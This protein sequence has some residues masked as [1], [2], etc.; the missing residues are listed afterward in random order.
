M[1]K[2]IIG[3]SAALVIAAI[4]G[5]VILKKDLVCEYSPINLSAI[6]DC[7]PVIDPDDAGSAEIQ[8]SD[9]QPEITGG[10]EITQQ[11]ADASAQDAEK[12]KAAE[13][14]KLAEEAAE[15]AAQDAAK[16]EEEAAKIAAAEKAVEQEAEPEKA[17]NVEITTNET[18]AEQTSKPV[19]AN[20]PTFDL[21]RVEPDG[22]TL[23]AG[24]GA[25]NATIILRDG[26]KN[27][28][29][30]ISGES[31]EWVIIVDE[32]IKQATATLSLL[33]LLPDGSSIESDAVVNIAMRNENTDATETAEAETPS[34]EL[35]EAD[36]KLEDEIEK[37]TEEIANNMSDEPVATDS[38][39]SESVTKAIETAEVAAKEA[40]DLLAKVEQMKVDA[41][42]A[43][44]AAKLAEAKAAADE[45]AKVEAAKIEAAKVAEAKTTA[46]ELAKAEAVK[47]AEAEAAKTAEAEALAAETVVEAETMVAETNDAEADATEVEAVETEA[48][49]QPIE[50][51]A[52]DTNAETNDPAAK[53]AEQIAAEEAL[54]A[55]A[56][57]KVEAEV[58]VE[59]NEAAKIAA[60]AK[61][62]AEAEKAKMDADA[63]LQAE[64]DA[65]TAADAQATADATAIAEAKIEADLKA[66]L[67]AE[68]IAQA[69][70]AAKQQAEIA[71][72]AKAEA[73]TKIAAEIAANAEA[74]LAAEAILAAEAKAG[75]EKAEAAKI[76][77]A[78]AQTNATPLVVI[79]EKG[80]ATKVLQ[81]AGIGA[82]NNEMTFNSMDYNEQGE[83]IF[84]GDAAANE[85][86]RVY[87]N[88]EFVG[89]AQAD[90]SGDWILNEGFVI[91]AGPNSMRFDQVDGDGNVISR[92]VTE[93][94]MPKLAQVSVTPNA[95]ADLSATIDNSA[96]PTVIND[97]TTIAATN[98]GS[99]QTSTVANSTGE[100]SIVVSNDSG[101][102]A[103]ANDVSNN[104]E[105]SIASGTAS[106]E[107]G[108]PTI[109]EVNET[110][111][112]DLIIT[113]V[114]EQPTASNKIKGGKAII[115]W[116]DNLWNISRKLYGKGSLYTTIFKANQDQI[117]DPN[118]IYPG[119]V[120]I[121]PDMEL[122]N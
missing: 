35:T 119:Q 94:N 83:V 41:A 23:V 58:E 40:E 82:K 50:I 47:I 19:D 55:E 107:T 95:D 98:N 118:L 116:G 100:S 108:A 65:K 66:K 86:V 6:I 7:Q 18:S 33:A 81:G 112:S 105:T 72:Q 54:A 104:A 2:Y 32:P 56:T 28:G 51:A 5:F 9:N 115:I 121:L 64:A 114:A 57:A 101:D 99:N 71:Q 62:T 96:A 29:E 36:K 120:F 111:T 63:K 16:A 25:P 42:K 92:R 13:E 109:A 15:Q 84:S 85:L 69:E 60:D 8:Q 80:K 20:M 52:N 17:A 79:T 48:E 45:I 89:E 73:E 61:A 38:E 21:V 77:A 90:S 14:A 76:E 122:D 68:E 22:S 87:V 75:A 3:G 88:N 103:G 24:R 78:K 44:E 27:I 113:P 93:I 37:K 46:D 97:E 12:A 102:A 70:A 31:G 11:T 59:A 26:D 74:K 10:A 67:A 106:G 110:D 34:V 53:T 49:Q 117:R 91:Q 4:A 43:A 1:N 30:A 39:T